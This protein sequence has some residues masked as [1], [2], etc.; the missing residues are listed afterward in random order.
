[1]LTPTKIIKQQRKIVEGDI[2]CTHQTI[3]TYLS[4]FATRWTVQATQNWRKHQRAASVASFVKS[5]SSVYN[6]ND[7][8]SSCVWYISTRTVET[9]PRKLARETFLTRK[10][11][12]LWAQFIITPIMYILMFLCISL[13]TTRKLNGSNPDDS[14]TSLILIEPSGRASHSPLHSMNI[15]SKLTLWSHYIIIV[16]M[17]VIPSSPTTTAS[18]NPGRWV[19]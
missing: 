7:W 8:I 14:L 18:H 6:N 11:H 5:C 15:L 12:F 10:G 1:M 16:R 2:F 13:I 17:F 3:N 19:N 4:R 9:A